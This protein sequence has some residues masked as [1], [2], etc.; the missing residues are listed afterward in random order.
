M[1]FKIRPQTTPRDGLNLLET[2]KKVC[3]RPSMGNIP[4]GPI[5]NKYPT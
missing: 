4:L 2:H 1:G 3:I 5:N